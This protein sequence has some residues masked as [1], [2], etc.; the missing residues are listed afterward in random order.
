MTVF[1]LLLLALA[2]FALRQNLFVV[3]GCA[4]GYAYLVWGD[5]ILDYIVLDG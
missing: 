3:L 4:A 2:L 5:G 1:G